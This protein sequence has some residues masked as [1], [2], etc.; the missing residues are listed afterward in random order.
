MA[1]FNSV[2]YSK[3]YRDASEKAKRIKDPEKLLDM[4][5]YNHRN[6]SYS[7]EYRIEYQAC[8]DEFFSRFNIIPEKSEECVKDNQETVRRVDYKWGYYT[9]KV[10]HSKRKNILTV[11]ASIYNK[12][13]SREIYPYS[14]TYDKIWWRIKEYEPADH[15]FSSPRSALNAAC[16]ALSVD[17]AGVR[18]ERTKQVDDMRENGFTYLLDRIEKDQNG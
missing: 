2:D 7:E 3:I 17:M 6:M 5:V 8:K 13:F 10:F 1:K 4:L 12:V 9:Y 16:N 14:K 18:K 15:N 11:C